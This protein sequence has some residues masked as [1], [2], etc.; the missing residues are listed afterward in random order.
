EQESTVDAFKK[1][2]KQTKN[3]F[4]RIHDEV[5]ANGPDMRKKKSKNWLI[6]ESYIQT[7]VCTSL[8]NN[9]N[10]KLMENPSCSPVLDILAPPL[11]DS[12]SDLEYV[13]NW[14]N[15][16]LMNN[17]RMNWKKYFDDGKKHG[18]FKNHKN[19]KNLKNTYNEKYSS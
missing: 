17:K 12:I 9:D 13:K 4:K 15:K 14:K 2:A 6:T 18:K 7:D 5:E 16:Y 19:P 10:N 8:N 1:L 11:C 3:Q